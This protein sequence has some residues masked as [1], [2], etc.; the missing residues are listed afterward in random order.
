MHRV[1]S[2]EERHLKFLTGYS[3]PRLGR[4]VGANGDACSES[5]DRAV[6]LG[7]LVANSWTV[8]ISRSASGWGSVFAITAFLVGPLSVLV[9]LLM[10]GCFFPVRHNVLH[11]VI[12]EGLIFEVFGASL[13]GLY[14]LW[15]VGAGNVRMWETFFLKMWLGLLVVGFG[16]AGLF[17]YLGIA[18]AWRPMIARDGGA[19][20]HFAAVFCAA[21]AAS[22]C[23]LSGR[24]WLLVEILYR[25]GRIWTGSLAYFF[26]LIIMC[27]SHLFALVMVFET[28][29]WFQARGWFT[30]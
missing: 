2:A 28:R 9:L 30:E 23:V 21:L 7:R 26:G 17:F 24:V 25:K 19:A 4:H 14:T 16:L 18:G 27:S 22:L 15:P 10:D 29:G 6:T 3:A 5:R 11:V 1:H 13:F 8:V 20:V 12:S